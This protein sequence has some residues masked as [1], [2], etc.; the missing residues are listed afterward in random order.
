MRHIKTLAT[1]LIA[2]TST[3]ASA[4]IFGAPEPE[5]YRP[6]DTCI[7]GMDLSFLKKEY[8]EE[9][10]AQRSF[11]RLLRE[12]LLAGTVTTRSVHPKELRTYIYGKW[13][14]VGVRFS[15]FEAVNP[16]I[17]EDLV[18]G[19]QFLEIKPEV[20]IWHGETEETKP[21]KDEQKSLQVDFS[22]PRG[23]QQALNHY[24][25]E[26][27]GS[28]FEGYKSVI[29][30]YHCTPTEEYIPLAF[31]RVDKAP[32]CL[33]V[34]VTRGYSSYG[35]SKHGWLIYERHETETNVSIAD[36]SID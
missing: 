9:T 2:L 16:E 18:E 29:E 14:A 26:E 4:Q 25:V 28:E 1:A 24:F 13:K 34:E 22:N 12:D 35:A 11:E 6:G 5:Y 23:K 20:E 33:A 8:A 32:D 31:T 15:K 3:S 30:I 10:C 36:A 17:Y 7:N 27:E 19:I 21:F